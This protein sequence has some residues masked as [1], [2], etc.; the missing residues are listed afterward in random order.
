MPILSVIGSNNVCATSSSM[1]NVTGANTYTWNTGINSNSITVSPTVTTTYTVVGTNSVNCSSSQTIEVTVDNTCQSVWPGDANSDGIA[2]NL[3]VLE[4]GLHYTQTGAA[5]TTTS[6]A[7]QAYTATNWAGTITNGKNLN[8]S[9][10]NGDGAINADDT[11]AIYNNYGLTHTFKMSNNQSTNPAL[12]IVPDQNLVYSNTWGTS[13]VYLG[14]A[15]N[16]LSNVNGIAFTLNYDNSLIETDSVYLEYTNSFI[17]S[18]QNLHFRK[19]TF[20]NS[21]L[22]TATTH[23]NNVNANGYGKIATLHYKIKPTLTT[24]ATLNISATQAVVSNAS[25]SIT[26]ITSGS[27]SLTAMALTTQLNNFTNDNIIHVYPNPTSSELH[28]ETNAGI[29]NA[30]LKLTNALGQTALTE[31]VN[32]KQQ[33]LSTSGLAKGVYVLELWQGNKIIYRNKLLKE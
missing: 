13:S 16:P 32:T 6:N 22:Y 3:D 30:T 31:Q 21:V 33:Q 10:C 9:D 17:N 8:H 18:G 20:A 29:E 15:T 27:V 14:D 2:D 25:G 5:R 28:I 12:S 4:L 24:N 26:P 19:N 1:L 11:L 23:T 7:W